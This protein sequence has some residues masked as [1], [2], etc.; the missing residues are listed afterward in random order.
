MNNQD[1]IYVSFQRN[2]GSKKDN[3]NK[4]EQNKCVNPI[5]LQALIR[6]RIELSINQT[7]A[8]NV[9]LFPKNTFR[10]IESNR[11]IPNVSQCARI[12]Q[13]FGVEIKIEL[14][15]NSDDT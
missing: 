1:W 8:D 2:T 7:D 4:L 3:S 14:V 11:L 10:N 9:C 13:C 12:Y 15:D 6:K 5:S